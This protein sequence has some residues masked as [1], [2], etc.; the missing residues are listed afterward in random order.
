M[1]PIDNPSKRTLRYKV[2]KLMTWSESNIKRLS[3]ELMWI[4]CNSD[5]TEFILR[6]GFGNAV[7]MLGMRGFVNIPEGNSSGGVGVATT[8]EEM[9]QQ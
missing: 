8:A 2:I 7:H 5:P 1:S 9:L 6:T 4:L 3:A